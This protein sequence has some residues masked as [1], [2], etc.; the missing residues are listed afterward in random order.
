MAFLTPNNFA[1]LLEFSWLIIV[2]GKVSQLNTSTKDWDVMGR[3][4]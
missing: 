2:S 3:V 1:I 4:C